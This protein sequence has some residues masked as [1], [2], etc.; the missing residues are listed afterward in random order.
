MMLTG[1]LYDVGFT[2]VRRL[3]RGE[4][5][6]RAHRGHLFQV[7]QRAGMDPRLITLIYWGFT[8]FGAAAAWCFLAAPSLYKPVIVL[9]PLAPPMIWT[10]YVIHRARL[11]DVGRWS[12]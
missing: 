9:V 4:N 10:L 5:I 8:L 6:T 12:H 3:L 2:L 7:A 1:A 11:K